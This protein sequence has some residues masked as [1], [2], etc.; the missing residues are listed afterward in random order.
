[1]K[2]IKGKKAFKKSLFASWN[3][4]NEKHNA[5]PI[6][7]TSNQ[8]LLIDE[9]NIDSTTVKQLFRIQ[10]AKKFKYQMYYYEGLNELLNEGL[11]F[12]HQKHEITLTMNKQYIKVE[13]VNPKFEMTTINLSENGL[14]Q[15]RK[16]DELNKVCHKVLSD[17]LERYESRK[18]GLK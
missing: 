16:Y 11:T 7:A 18:N 2:D 12:I 1:M 6:F 8:D 14:K 9:L 5:N 13:I 3:G 15:L 10:M 17:I 4:Q